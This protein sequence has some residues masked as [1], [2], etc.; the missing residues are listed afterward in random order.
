MAT[1]GPGWRAATIAA[2][3]L[4]CGGALAERWSVFKARPVS[5]SDPRAVVGPQ[6]AG[7]ESGAR[8]GAARSAL[9]RG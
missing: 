8:Q 6:R 1:R 4:L 9:R 2:A 7:I 5:A 3:T